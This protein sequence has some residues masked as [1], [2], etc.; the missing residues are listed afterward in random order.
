MKVRG[1]NLSAAELKQSP[2]A[3]P[4]R[5]NG[6]Q[7]FIYFQDPSYAMALN[8]MTIEKLNK[9]NAS[10]SKYIGFLRNSYTVWNPA[11]FISNFARDFEMAIANAAA[12]IER[13]GGILQGYGLD[14]KTFVKALTKTTFKT[15]KALVKQ[16]VS[17]LLVPRS[18][19]RHSSTWRSGKPLVARLDSATLKPLTK[20][21]PSSTVSPTRHLLSRKQ[22]KW[23]SS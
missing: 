8:G 19:L 2:N 22:R 16:S 14:T 18:M 3:V 21:W 4:I 11:F 1:R 10:M 6:E 15:M 23:V 13:E 20:W 5:I 17:G 9:I 7:H 12:E